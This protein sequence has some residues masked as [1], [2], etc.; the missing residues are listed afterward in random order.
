ML[1]EIV[2]FGVGPVVEGDL[3]LA[4]SFGA[5]VYAFNTTVGAKLEVATKLEAN[6]RLIVDHF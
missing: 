4:Q 1:L 6:F 2:H 3:S 5:I